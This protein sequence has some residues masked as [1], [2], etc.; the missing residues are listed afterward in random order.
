MF[1]QLPE[2]LNQ[3]L[4]AA[5]GA[6]LMFLIN[7]RKELATT[8]NS[9]LDNVEKAVS[10]W[11]NMTVDLEERIKLLQG[12]ISELRKNVIELQLENQTLKAQLAQNKATS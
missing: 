1:D 3:P 8:R 9:E 7:K 6:A 11:R 12:E 2:W 5:I 10:I 4:S